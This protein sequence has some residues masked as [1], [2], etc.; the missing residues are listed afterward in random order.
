MT[1]AD[2]VIQKFS[3]HLIQLYN[4]PYEEPDKKL[5]ADVEDLL[6]YGNIIKQ[7]SSILGQFAP[8]VLQ[9]INSNN[10]TSATKKYVIRF[11]EIVLPYYSFT[12][13][14]NIFNEELM[15]KVFQGPDYLKKVLAKVIEKAN[16]SK[17]VHGPLFHELFK[18]F[19]NSNTE[20]ST[21]NA[22]EKAIVTLTLKSDEIRQKYLSDPDICNILDDMK[23][24]TVVQ[25]RAIDLICEILPVIP[26]LPTS[27]Y[28]VS[29]EELALSNDLLFYRFCVGSWRS[30]LHLIDQNESLNFLKKKM[31][32][33]FDFCA[34]KFVG[35]PTLLDDKD[36]FI[37]YDDFG[38]VYLLVTVSFVIPAYFK[39][40]DDKYSLIDYAIETY[41]H[42]NKSKVLLSSVNTIF[43]RERNTLFENFKL[44][45]AYVE[46]FCHLLDDHIILQQ[47]L[48]AEHFPSS[49]F[50]RLVFD[51][52]FAIF[53]TLCE[54]R[55]KITKM[56]ESWPYVI[57]KVISSN[58][59]NDVI[60][61]SHSLEIYLKSILS[62]SV[63][64]GNLE[65]PIEE[66][67]KNLQ[68]HINIT[69]EE[70]L[71]ESL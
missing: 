38:T 22:V 46:L 3:H 50:E 6:R 58:I 35:K 31:E 45:N 4:D 30:L 51:D 8:I 33:Q 71:T 43:L 21:A 19:A 26:S 14:S 63:P 28:L 60:I 34:R 20:I 17:I 52:L 11:L 56:V 55:E 10:T 49:I 39:T 9:I 15:V 53:G 13:V 64:L 47:K 16:P 57:S 32:P 42:Y 18:T 1:I 70:P 37:D 66:K 2:P 41:S 40:L 65:S 69:V 23:H 68:G 12:E 67:L 5:L 36:I 27:V 7:D 24:D 61:K 44:S 25:S 54:T 62:S 48:T 29:E 59:T